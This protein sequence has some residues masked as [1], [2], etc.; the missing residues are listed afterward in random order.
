[1]VRWLYSLLFYL[2]MP[3]VCLRLLWRARRQPEYLQHLGERLGFYPPFAAG[4]PWIWLHAV[5]VGETRAAEPLVDALLAAYP[6]HR[7]LLTHMTPTGR[8]AAG[9]LLRRHPQRL[10]QAYLPY[11]LPGACERFADH[12]QPAI[13]L[14]ME[15]EI[16]PNL[17]AAVARRQRPLALVNARLSARSQRGYSRLRPLIEPALAGLAAVAAQSPADAARLQEIGASRVTVVGN[18]KFDV[19]PA[20]EKLALGGQWRQAIGARPVLLV[21]STRDGEETLLLDAL[22]SLAINDLLLVLVPRHPQRFDEVARLLAT[23]R[24]EFCRRSGAAPP[25]PQTRVWLG[26]S[27]GEMAAYYALADLALIGG[28]WLPFGG[29]NLIEAAACG[30]PVLMGPHMFNFEQASADAVHTG[31]ACRVDD[32]SSAARLTE[33]LLGGDQQRLLAMRVAAKTFSQTHQGATARTVALIDGLMA[34]PAAR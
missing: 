10:T 7:L 18:L 22:D 8:A 2:A 5:S 21:A 26:D 33:E 32:A 16:W 15:T 20:P 12:F 6:S 14:L 13:G 17:I 29:Q 27:M 24:L 3:L 19:T 25:G 9:E 30:C 4:A 28:S 34:R 23:R 31:A 11:D 1:M